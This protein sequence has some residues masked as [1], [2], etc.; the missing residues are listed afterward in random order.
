MI[1]A[2]Q[3]K[4]FMAFGG[5]GVRLELAPLTMLFGPNNGGKST[6]IRALQLLTQSV[7]MDDQR[8]RHRTAVTLRPFIERGL[9]DLGSLG[10]TIHGR[11]R[12]HAS[13][14]VESGSHDR[15]SRSLPLHR[16]GVRRPHIEIA[17]VSYGEF[18][19]VIFREK[20]EERL[21]ARLTPSQATT[22]AS[23]RWQA[24]GGVGWEVIYSKTGVRETR[25]S[26]AGRRLATWDGVGRLR[27]DPDVGIQLRR[28]VFEV[29]ARFQ[30]LDEKQPEN[31]VLQAMLVG[32]RR[33]IRETSD[34]SSGGNED[35]ERRFLERRYVNERG[36]LC[37]LL[38]LMSE[39]ERSVRE[40]LF[41]YTSRDFES[42]DACLRFG[43]AD[44]SEELPGI[45]A[46]SATRQLANLLEE[47]LE[48]AEKF[49]SPA[50]SPYANA[51][52]AGD[53]FDAG[54]ERS[55][56]QKNLF[57]KVVSAIEKDS[58][59]ALGKSMSPAEFEDQAA[60][61]VV[62]IAMIQEIALNLP[63]T[64]YGVTRE[65][66]EAHFVSTRRHQRQRIARVPDRGH[67]G[68]TSSDDEDLL[69]Q[70][71]WKDGQLGIL[72]AGL[73]RLEIPY[74]IGVERIAETDFY[75]VV[76]R[77]RG[78]EDGLNVSWADVG[79]GMYYL[80]PILLGMSRAR[81]LLCVEEPEAHLHPGL[82]ARLADLFLAFARLR[83]EMTP[84]GLSIPGNQRPQLLVETHSEH[85]LLRVLRRIREGEVSPED[86]SINYISRVR[87]ESRIRRLQVDE[88]GE[89]VG[90]WPR[91]FFE[92]RLEDIL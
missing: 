37:D 81:G 40:K 12:R 30:G 80:M 61:F 21:R 33:L 73:E 31:F 60:N 69:Q 6:V 45:K 68:G 66:A 9:V 4:N 23:D 19:L 8:V 76:F 78:V 55:A 24:R 44:F 87:G 57:A 50:E 77:E 91:G 56:P 38:Y 63:V 75:Q 34:V 65:V 7:C 51:R 53:S 67:V 26:M 74:K 39:R 36:T 90:G 62:V 86:V 89:F 49:V 64:M 2:V 85:L 79:F 13:L 42:D 46:A 29:L 28:G 22:Q 54:G 10:E 17:R 82:Q 70:L 58:K 1:R 14:L 92:E 20:G 41:A 59:S 32:A 52:R 48:N 27:L 84:S 18:D 35:F 88:S 15:L 11:S 3:L 43:E 16:A 72:N 47:C 83:K 25:M 71:V 5:R